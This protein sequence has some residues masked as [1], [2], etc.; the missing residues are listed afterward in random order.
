MAE[1]KP[2]SK[3]KWLYRAMLILN[4]VFVAAL[5]ISYLAPFTH[6]KIT[7]LPA[8][9]ALVFPILWLANALFAIFWMLRLRYYFLFSLLSL[10]IGL[11]IFMRMV[12]ISAPATREETVSDFK[13]ISYNVRLF[14]QYKWRSDQDY[15]TR[16]AVFGFTHSQ[17]PDIVCF[18]EFFHGNNTYFPTIGPFVAASEAKNYHVGY[19]KTVGDKKHYGLATFTRFPIV[20]RAEIQFEDAVSNSGIFTDVVVKTDTIR[21]FNF[22]LESVRFSQADY[23][24]VSE[25]ID[26]A[27]SGH[28]SSSRIIFYKLHKAFLRRARQAAV[29]RQYI[30]Q[31]PYPV[32]VCG[33]FNDTPASFV[34]RTISKNL[35]DAF[36]EAGTGLG[37][38]YAGGLPFLRIDYILH[39]PQL[40]A[41]HYQKHFVDYSDH[42][43]I[44]CSFS[45]ELEESSVGRKKVSNPQ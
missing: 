6:P 11:N 3:K 16:D 15:F 21:I 30:S 5:L 23:K 14:D 10:I 42:Y 20:N 25:V 43:P 29:V 44:S 17:H 8:M 24:F 2:G 7:T 19:V 45:L 40:K 27:V 36:L 38:T 35:G 18:Q 28:S 34:Y 13:I 22:H 4:F 33:D 32:I 31:S 41:L 12:S 26:P 1:T 9:L 37:T 39:S